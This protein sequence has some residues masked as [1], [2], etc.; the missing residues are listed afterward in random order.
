VGAVQ[1]QSFLPVTPFY[2]SESGLLED[3][4]CMKNNI[5][6]QLQQ[7]LQERNFISGLDLPKQGL[8]RPIL[9][10]WAN[11]KKIVD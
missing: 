4:L 6:G 8:R 3:K 9:E 1:A 10:G 7:S 5:L 2:N 11:F